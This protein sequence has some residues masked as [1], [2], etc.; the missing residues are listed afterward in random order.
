MA[1]LRYY[2]VHND[3]LRTVRVCRS[4]NET[5]RNVDQ[6]CRVVQIEPTFRNEAMTAARKICKQFNCLLQNVKDGPRPG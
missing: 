3:L 5:E 2:M 1:D 4:L 6:Y